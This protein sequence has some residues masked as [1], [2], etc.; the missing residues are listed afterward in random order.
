MLALPSE[1]YVAELAGEGGADVDRIHRARTAVQHAIGQHCAGSLLCRYEALAVDEPYAPVGSQIAARSLRN[2]CLAYMA[3]GDRA[4]LD[5]ARAQLQRAANMTDRFAALKVLAFHG[6]AA[7][8]EAP[9]AHFYADWGH[10]TLA[11]NQWLALQAAM[12]DEGVLAR[13]RSLMAHPAFDL[14]NPNKVRSLIGTFTAQNPVN[15]HRTDG[16]GYRLLREVVAEL[17]GINPQ[18]A[19]RLLTPLTKWRYYTGRQEMMR[20]ELEALAAGD[21][22]SPDVYEVVSKSLR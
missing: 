1:N 19:S 17:D 5:L 2:L 7:D 4:S 11:A 12:P 3:A 9:L 13:V 21:A 15:F 14:R 10:E 18:I 8:W 16:A 22:L 6:K 20:A